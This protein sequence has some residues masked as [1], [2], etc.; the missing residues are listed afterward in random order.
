MQ[1]PLKTKEMWQSRKIWRKFDTR[2]TVD[3]NTGIRDLWLD[4]N[5]D[6]YMVTDGGRIIYRAPD[7][8]I[9]ELYNGLN[10]LVGIWGASA[11]EF[12]VTGYMDEMIL[13]CSY[14]PVADVFSATPVV[15]AFPE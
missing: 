13:R 1:F 10:A 7:G 8:T 14:D 12:W 3:R 2:I 9:R 6:L 15:L 4:A 5:G 11:G